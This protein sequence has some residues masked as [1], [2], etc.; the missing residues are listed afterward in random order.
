MASFSAERASDGLDRLPCCT[1]SCAMPLYSL[2]QHMGLG[3]RPW[4][5]DAR[6]NVEA[7]P[8][9]TLAQSFDRDVEPLD[10]ECMRNRRTRVG[11]G[12]ELK[13]AAS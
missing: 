7:Y 9:C 5:N 13:V 8:V 12:V 2:G 4:R 1:A 3:A 11:C 6:P 10:G